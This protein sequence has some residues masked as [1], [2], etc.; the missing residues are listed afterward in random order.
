MIRA[1]G[2]D[3]DVAPCPRLLFRKLRFL[4]I[5]DS[6]TTSLRCGLFAESGSHRNSAH[7]SRRAELALINHFIPLAW[8]LVCERGRQ[9]TQIRVGLPMYRSQSEPSLPLVGR[10]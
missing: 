2:A 6:Y 7:L 5:V 9:K 3:D 10:H 8:N 4:V 1:S